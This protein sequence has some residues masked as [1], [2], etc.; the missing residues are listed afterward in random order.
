M[1]MRIWNG[2]SEVSVKYR[3]GRFQ[4]TSSFRAT[5]TKRT[6]RGKVEEA[7]EEV[8]EEEEKEEEREKKERRE[9][10][11]KEENFETRSGS[12]SRSGPGRR[13]S[14]KRGRREA[15]SPHWILMG[16]TKHFLSQ[17][18]SWERLGNKFSRQPLKNEDLAGRRH[19][20]RKLNV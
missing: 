6:I 16:M 13:G 3:I 5:Q 8:E 18:G 7:V 15:N 19:Q 9:L 4:R 17:G 20:R 10:K 14:K 11:E 1:A 12:N 2:G